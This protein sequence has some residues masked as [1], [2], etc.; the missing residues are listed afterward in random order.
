MRALA[1]EGLPGPALAPPEVSVVVPVYRNEAT[2]LELL[3]RLQRA[4][5]GEDYELILVVDGSPDGSL[6]LL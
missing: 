1:D 2:L 6:E 4:L 3:D 5:D